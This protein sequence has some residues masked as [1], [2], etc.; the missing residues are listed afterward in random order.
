MEPAKKILIIQTA[1]IGD[2]VLSTGIMESLFHTIPNLKIGV[3]VRSGNES[4]FAN[5][6]FV[7][8]VLVWNKKKGKY[9]SLLEILLVIRKRKYDE[10]INLHRFGSSGFL[11][12]FSGAKVKVG[13][14][15]NPFSF[16]F[17][18]AISHEIGNGVHENERNHALIAHLCGNTISKP[19]LYPSETNFQSVKP[20]SEGKFVV[21]APASV[22]FTKQLPET[23]WVELI[24]KVPSGYR[25]YLVGGP[26]DFELCQ[27]LIK[28]SSHSSIENLCGKL[29]YL[30]TCALFSSSY[31]NFVNDSG[32]LHFCSAMNAPVTA[33]FCSTIPDFGFG[34]LS[35]HSEIIECR[36]ELTCRPCGLHGKNHCPEGHFNCG[37][38]INLDEI[39]F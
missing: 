11:T 14:K 30:D 12:V 10:V 37:M 1:F 25:I 34:P 39:K 23:K 26:G 31:M 29:S 35:D 6:P 18:K 21:M 15:K 13:F 3:L 24:K 33:F 27:R 19:K 4:L 32:P 7:K 22:W 38:K 28:R 16:L 20:F 36:E 9:K 5:H 8:E 17:S 2:V